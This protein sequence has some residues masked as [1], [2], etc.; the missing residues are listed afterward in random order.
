[1]RGGY[2]RHISK[3]A[4]FS[5]QFALLSDFFR[6]HLRPW[7]VSFFI[8]FLF[9]ATVQSSKRYKSVTCLAIWVIQHMQ[10]LNAIIKFDII[11]LQK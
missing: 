1:M 9:I 2:L 6:L 5:S 10:S 8:I 7:T 4:W 3:I 11:I